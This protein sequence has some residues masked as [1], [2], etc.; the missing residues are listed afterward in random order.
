[1][2]LE[3]RLEFFIRQL[4]D[5]L[6]ARGQFSVD[7]GLGQRQRRCRNL[8]LIG[9][10]F[11]GGTAAPME[12]DRRLLFENEL[13]EVPFGAETDLRRL[14][15]EILVLGNA[16]GVVHRFGLVADLLDLV[17]GDGLGERL[18][19]SFVTNQLGQNGT[20]AISG[21]GPSVASSSRTI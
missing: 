11:V 14:D 16:R 8:F 17:D 21:R 13:A 6:H 10:G 2:L 15:F 18:A 1:V 4:G 19:C 3:Q 12:A 7:P 20:S 9:T 5:P